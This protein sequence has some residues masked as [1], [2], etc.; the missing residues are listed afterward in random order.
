M[1]DPNRMS[2]LVPN[3]RDRDGR[4]VAEQSRLCHCRCLPA[5]TLCLRALPS[6][7]SADVGL[8]GLA[9]KRFECVEGIH[10]VGHIEFAYSLRS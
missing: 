3:I 2:V 5:Q 8:T 6:R 4:Y 10:S 9:L 1:L 7:R